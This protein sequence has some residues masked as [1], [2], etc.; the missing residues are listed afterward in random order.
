MAW[1][2][3]ASDARVRNAQNPTDATGPV[4]PRIWGLRDILRAAFPGIRTFYTSGGDVH[5]AGRA[6]DVMVER[7][8][9]LGTQVADFLVEHAQALGVQLVIWDR[10]IWVATANRAPTSSPYTGE[11]SH[12][13]HV[14]VELSPDAPVEPVLGDGGGSRGSWGVVLGALALAGLAWFAVTRR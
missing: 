11:S 3:P 5:A 7:G 1:T 2:P 4:D 14:H 13:D 6:L 12:T 8:S 10:T 9:P